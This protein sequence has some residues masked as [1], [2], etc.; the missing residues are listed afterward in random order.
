VEIFAI[1]GCEL[2][3]VPPVVDEDRL[4]VFPTHTVVGPEI[5]PGNANTVRYLVLLHP[6]AKV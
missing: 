4:I 5:L 1:L 6:F 3:Q 2:L